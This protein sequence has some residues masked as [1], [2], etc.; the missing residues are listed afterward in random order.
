MSSIMLVALTWVTFAIVV[1]GATDGNQFV[2]FF[3]QA[4][5]RLNE[6]GEPFL[7]NGDVVVVD[8]CPTHHGR[9]GQ[10]LKEYLAL[11]GIE[12]LY[13]PKYSP[14]M[15]PAE[16][17]FNKIRTLVKQKRYRDMY[18]INAG[19]TIYELLKEISA[20]DC[21]GFFKVTKYLDV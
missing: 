15:N 8:N 16:F 12:V 6:D 21:I 14:E 7:T 18:H 13:T 9:F 2:E 17:T 3:G 11:C 19:Y 5:Q 20:S 1:Q 10:E 4:T